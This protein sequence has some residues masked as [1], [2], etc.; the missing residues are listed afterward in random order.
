[1][2]SMSRRRGRRL[3]EGLP[4]CSPMREALRGDPRRVWLLSSRC[5]V[6]CACAVLFKCLASCAIPYRN[7]A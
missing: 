6:S 3:G 4:S 7:V 5:K 2:F 1:M